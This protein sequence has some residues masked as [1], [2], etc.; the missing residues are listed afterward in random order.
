MITESKSKP[1][2]TLI[3][4]SSLGIVEV[5]VNITFAG[6]RFAGVGILCSLQRDAKEQTKLCPKGKGHQYG[7][8]SRV[9]TKNNIIEYARGSYPV[10]FSYVPN[11]NP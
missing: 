7:S 4:E 6:V 8:P 9:P 3:S 5:S 1:L 2:T 10:S 11:L